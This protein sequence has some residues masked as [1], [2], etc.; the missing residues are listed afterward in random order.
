MDSELRATHN[1]FQANPPIRHGAV[2]GISASHGTSV[3]GIVFG[4][5][6]TNAAGK[7]M[8][9]AGQ[10]I[11]AS[12][13]TLS[14]RY[15]HTARLLQPAYE[16]V[17]QTNSWG[18]CCTTA[19]G[20]QAADADTMLFDNRIVLLQ[21][22]ANTGNSSSDVIAFAKNLI[23]VGG[24]R[25]QNTLTLADD[26]HGGTSGST[27]PASDG[28]IKP[29]LSFWYDGIFTTSSSSNTSY[30][31]SFGGTSAATP[32]TAGHVGLM[33][34]MWAAGIFGNPVSP[35]GTVFSNRPKIMTA[36][37]LMVNTASPYPFSGTT[38]DLRRLRQG[39][40]RAD[41]K[42]MHDLRGKM[43][44]VNE[45]DTL[46]N[47]QVREYVV[48]VP[49]GEPELRA[50]LAYIDPAGTPNSTRHRVNDLSLEVVAPDGTVYFGNNGL[51]AGNV[52]TAGGAP[53]VVDTVENVW[54][55]S[56]AAG[57]WRVRVRGD[58]IV[59]DAVPGTPGVD[60]N[61]GLVVSG[62]TPAGCRG[63]WN[64]DGVIDFNDLLAYLNDY[65]AQDPRA[66]VNGDGVVDFNDLLAFLNL[67]N[68]GCP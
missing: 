65:N 5:G 20:T 52:S 48:S 53:N 28:R 38:A 15:Q 29:D 35:G 67:Y 11:F 60:A 41:V 62:V 18:S 66:D 40:G 13:S 22:Q 63:D 57:D 21:A 37:A 14:N 44:I 27:G 19:Y 61:Y 8:L 49:A 7:G 10:G 50:T 33:H 26:A 16:A 4:T 12:Y 59:R 31:S 42:R 46:T 23:S 43:F 56:P 30:T 17:F 51:L 64:G 58:E 3:F 54:V 2:G 55:P 45:S 24:I 36:K 6:V 25:H 34:Q 1:D 47:L 39:W 32:M 68:A 9:P